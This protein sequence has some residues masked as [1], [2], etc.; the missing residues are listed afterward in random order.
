MGKYENDFY[1]LG[2]ESSCD[3][4]AIAIYSEKQ[5]LI[6]HKLH[7]QVAIHNKYGGVVPEFASREHIL[8]VIPLINKTLIAANI[9][10]KQIDAIAYTKGPGL[11]GALLVGS[12]I[13]KSL[14]Y[15]LNI[16]SLGVN[17]MEGH[18]LAPLLEVDKPEMPFICL[19][20]SGGHTM[21]L[22][23]S[24]FGKYKLLGETLDDAA[25]E[26]FDKTAKLL[27]LG[28]PGG[29][30]LSKLATK[31]DKT[32]FNFPRPLLNKHNKNNLDF[33]FSGLKTFAKNTIA[34]NPNNL[35][36]IAC[37]FEDAVCDVLTTKSLIAL[38]KSK[39]STLVVAGGVSANTKL[40]DK[41]NNICYNNNYKVFYPRIEFCTDN[42]AMIALAGHIRL[43]KK[44]KDNDNIINIKPRWSLENI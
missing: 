20:V 41:I 7:S 1:T 6:N 28:Y 35:A 5:G 8:W 9:N 25:G 27:G 23:V 32:K 26:A 44:Q 39:L 10:I 19:L 42:A 13:A 16:P 14:A 31:G 11:A 3:E 40:R 43:M 4:T 15:S 37:C 36:D 12:S 21:L 33:S 34:N 2:I 29:A 22:Q 38:Q 30:K 18:L 17:H 24:D